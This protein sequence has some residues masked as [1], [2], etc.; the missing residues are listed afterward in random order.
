M[1]RPSLAALLVIA[2]ALASL[3]AVLAKEGHIKL[4]AVSDDGGVLRGSMA[5]LY[6]SVSDGSGRV[7]LDTYPLTKL[8]TQISTRFSSEV[9]C[10]LLEEDCAQRDFAYRIE[11]E[12]NIVGGPSAGAATAALTA[13][14]LAGLKVDESVALTGTINSGGLI[15]PVAGLK[16][17]IEAAAGA[18]LRLAALP[19]GERYFTSG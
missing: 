7:F 8:D 6:L 10:S 4:L 14:M 1:A 11:A 16:E 5:D 2:L 9:A 15:G 3:P 19:P 18:G 12:S 13:A 17:K